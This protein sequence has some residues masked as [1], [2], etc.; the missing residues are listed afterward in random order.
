MFRELHLPMNPQAVRTYPLN[1][2]TDMSDCLIDRT[3][4]SWLSPLEFNM[5]GDFSEH[6]HILE[7][8]LVQSQC[9]LTDEVTVMGASTDTL[10]IHCSMVLNRSFLV[11]CAINHCFVKKNNYFTRLRSRAK[12]PAKLHLWGGISMRGVTKLVW[13][14]PGLDAGYKMFCETFQHC[15]VPFANNTFNGDRF[16]SHRFPFFLKV[17]STGAGQRACTQKCVYAYTVNGR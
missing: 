7:S 5:I 12:H 8:V 1:I 16:T 11:G 15:H 4:P 13:I 9:I 17:W 3:A 2:V 10:T 14:L 6:I